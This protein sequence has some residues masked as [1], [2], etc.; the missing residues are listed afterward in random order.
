MAEG[1]VLTQNEVDAL[2]SAIG[3][4]EVELSPGEQTARQVVL[5]DFKRPE[6]VARDQLRAIETLHDVFA[7]NLQASLSGSLR[8]ILDLKISN[9]DQLTY[10]EFINSL[11][12]PTCFNVVNC[13]PLEGSFILEISPSIAFPI[14]ER[15]LGHG[16]VSTIHPE[17]PLTDIE[18]RLLQTVIDRAV[19]IMREVWENV[20]KINFRV[21]AR[22]SNP[23][24]VPIMSSNEPVVSVTLEMSMGEHKGFIN[25]CIPV[26]SIEPLMDKIIT[27]TWFTTKRR[28]AVPSQEAVI[29]RSLAVAD[30]NLVSYLAQT[31]MTIDELLTLEPGDIVVTEH[32]KEAP[33]IVMIEGQPK[34]FAAP[35]LFKDHRA[36]RVTA[37][38]IASDGET[39]K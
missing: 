25:V 20:E 29:T 36:I 10:S 26:V 22:E 7:R 5:Y 28:E 24:L 21:T 33:A 23:Q 13:E 34:L 17:R 32:H 9:I 2:L 1:D 27:H 19:Q 35:G 18:W 11:P 39:F 3:G 31:T 12:N 37:K 38:A 16:K 4:G 6:R 15:L 8:T 14:F 30:V